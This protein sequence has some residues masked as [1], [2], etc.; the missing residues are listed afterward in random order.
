[1]I[2]QTVTLITL[3]T[4]SQQAL[5]FRFETGE[6]WKIRWDNSF[7]FNLMSRVEKQNKDVYTSIAGAGWQLADDADLSVSRNNGG[8]V[9]TR[10]DLLSEFDVIWRD[11]YG[12]RI[13]GAA[14]YD[15]QYANS[16]S[17]HPKDRTLSWSNPNVPVSNYSPAARDYHYQGGELLD[18][19]MFAN[20]DIGDTALGIRAGRHTIYWGQGLLT[21]G[22]IHGIGGAMAPIDFSKAL[23]VPGSEAKELFMPT[24]KISAVLQLS[25][26]MTLN[27]YYGFEFQAYRLPQDGTYWSPAEGLTEDAEFITLIAGDP[28]RTGMRHRGF[29]G[30]KGDYGINLQYY[31]EDAGLDASFVYINYTDKNLHGLIGVIG[32]MGA[33]AVDASAGALTL[34]ESKWVFKNDIELYGIALARDIAGVSFG[35]DVVHRKNTGL[36]ANFKAAL[37]QSGVNFNATSPDNYPGAV[38]DTWGVNIS[39]LKFLNND[40]GLWQGGTAIIEATFSQLDKC[41]KNCQLL[42]T[43][44][45]EGRVVSQ[46]AAIFAPTWF[47]VRSGWDLT[48]PMSVSYTIDGEKSPLSFGGDEEAGTASIGARVSID[49]T[50]LVAAAYNV[51]YGPVLAGVGGLLKDRDN[52]SLTIKRTF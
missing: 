30:D 4:L 16:K 42:D 46:I 22:A 5:A 26:N 2:K 8:L 47:Q 1:M 40:W 9:S 49:Q 21:N 52:I 13:S 12:F 41:K 19:F 50:W 27:A 25:D 39:A 34:G 23:S 51:R 29:D 48:L 38:G 44:V 20:F 45:S 36:A 11:S 35:L 3:A 37:T 28:I 6:D 32:S 43:R 33:P 31:F 15:P 24:N 18:A 7:K 10:F 14:W 17:D